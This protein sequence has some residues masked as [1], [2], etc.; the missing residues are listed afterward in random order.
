M[1]LTT[2]AHD[3]L[4]ADFLAAW[5]SQDVERLLDCYTH[6]VRYRDPNTRGEIMAATRCD[7]IS[8]DCLPSGR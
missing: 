5:N 6:D 8:R 3:L 4:V 7:A 1:T 2:A